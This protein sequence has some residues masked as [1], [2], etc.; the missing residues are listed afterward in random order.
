MQICRG[1]TLHL[2]ETSFFF[3]NFSLKSPHPDQYKEENGIR[4]QEDENRNLCSR[5]NDQSREK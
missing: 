3:S 1:L 4:G 5:K 2:L